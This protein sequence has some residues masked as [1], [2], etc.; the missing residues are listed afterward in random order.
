MAR[1]TLTSLKIK[2]D[3]IL[4]PI[5]F[6]IIG[7]GLLLFVTKWGIG[8]SPDSVH[9]IGVARNFLNGNGLTPPSSV[10]QSALTTN[11]PPLYPTILALIGIFGIDPLNGARWL[12]A[13][14]FGANILLVGL[15][16]NRYTKDYIWSLLGSFFMLISVDMLRI[17]SMAW[18]E[19]LFIFFGLMGLFLLTKYIV[20]PKLLL[21]IASS[22]LMAAAS[23]VRYAGFALL[24][25]GIVVILLFIRKSFIRKIF[26]TF[27]WSII[28]FLPLA[29]WVV[30]NLYVAGNT[31]GTGRQ[32]I[33]HPIT[34]RHVGY[35]LETLAGWISPEGIPVISRV[36]LLI[37]EMVIMVIL[38]VL[39]RLLK[40]NRDENRSIKQNNVKIF[41]ILVTFIIIYLVFLIVTIL[42]FDVYLKLDY[43][44]LSPVY[45]SALI[46]I[47][48]LAQR[49]Q[50]IKNKTLS[51]RL[52]FLTLV[53]IMILTYTLNGIIWIM[54][55]HSDGQGYASK[56]WHHS[57]IIREVRELPSGIPIY[58]NGH[59]AIYILTGK[60]ADMIPEKVNASSRL[61]NENYSSQLILMGEQLENQGGFLVYLNAL[62]WRWYLPSD[63]E[64]KEQLPLQLL[65]KGADGSIYYIESTSP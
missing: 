15:V 50:N 47:F 61:T 44:I 7:I 9:Y 42:F 34:L 56:A 14:M 4:F 13:F 29:L 1:L 48:F 10:N 45:V 27:I 43:R 8:L 20:T 6:A 31:T 33:F 51:L 32:M 39:F 53:I 23:L 65:T 40:R 52:V 22:S 30:R 46:L 58:S 25:T 63:E 18:T 21:L 37:V 24:I 64:L 16:I 26:T 12:N 3:S 49:S 11:F 28:G 41:K 57:E 55:N 62:R 2:K 35:A 19:P 54:S 36:I 17:H 60:P 38:T 5:V 59:D